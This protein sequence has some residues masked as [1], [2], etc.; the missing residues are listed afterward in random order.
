MHTHINIHAYLYQYSYQY[1][2][3]HIN[4]DILISIYTNTYY[5]HAFCHLIV[6]I[7]GEEH[8]L[9]VGLVGN[10]KQVFVC[11]GNSYG[12]LGLGDETP[13]YHTYSCFWIVFEI[14]NRY[15]ATPLT[16]T[17]SYTL[18][19]HTQLERETDNIDVVNVTAVAAGAY[20]SLI[21]LDGFVYSFGKNSDGQL[22]LSSL[23]V[24]LL[25]A[26]RCS[27][28]ITVLNSISMCVVVSKYPPKGVVCHK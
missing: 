23:Q 9:L 17:G 27:V 14:T 25:F 6:V 10:T 13:R 24:C 7:G 2:Q 19:E 1:R 15:S 22:G 18:I 20:H 4:I 16:K 8:T 5:T 26:L 12:Q 21:V 11:G 28:L 3:T